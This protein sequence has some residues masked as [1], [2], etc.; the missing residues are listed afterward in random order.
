MVEQCQ[1]QEV[2]HK[3]EQRAV[4]DRRHAPLCDVSTQVIMSC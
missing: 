1:I 4:F 2:G 3:V